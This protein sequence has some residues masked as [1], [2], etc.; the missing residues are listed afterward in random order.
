MKRKIICILICTLLIIVTTLPVTG[1]IIEINKQKYSKS[2]ILDDLNIDLA[3]TNA[4]SNKVSI[5]LGDGSGGFTNSGSFPVENLPLGIT[6]GDFNGDGILDLITTSYDYHKVTVLLGDGAGGFSYSGSFSAGFYP[7]GIIDEDFN[8]DGNQDIAV[9][10]NDKDY[11]SVLLGDGT[12]NFTTQSSYTVGYSP[13]DLTDGTFDADDNC[14]LVVINL[15]Q[16]SV[17]VLLGDGAGGFVLSNSIVLGSNYKP[18]TITRGDFNKDENLDV[19]V[20]SGG[21]PFVGIL[22]GDGTGGFS[23]LKNYAVGDASERFDIIAADFNNDENPDIAVPNA[24]DNTV[25]VLLGNG[26]GGFEPHQT[27]PV[28]TYPVGIREGDFNADG[29]RDLAVTN[30][31]D[32]TIGILLGDGTGGFGAQQIYPAGDGPVGIISGN[33]NYIPVPDLECQGSL[34]WTKIKPTESV[35]GEF[36]IKNLGDPGSKLNWEISEY[37]SDW[38]I[39]WHFIPD[40]GTGLTPEAG[41]VTVNISFI[42]PITSNKKFFGKIK[43]INVDN[44]SDYC[45]LDVYLQIP[46]S[47]PIF[48]SLLYRIFERFLNTFP[49]FRQLL[50]I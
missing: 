44:L 1:N 23:P 28:G 5:L 15:D 41:I 16:N 35:N 9:A 27:Y 40:S 39:K 49:M 2:G 3:I 43:V 48:H 37:P 26:T 22:L 38:D 8:K 33:I 46:R 47:K 31:N 50:E 13:V 17:G 19:A 20:A 45:E 11:I 25:S 18:T 10:N 42:A 30:T 12:G 34:N 14:D 36:K 6:D 24:D 4:F 7:V 32:N 29:N 21:Y